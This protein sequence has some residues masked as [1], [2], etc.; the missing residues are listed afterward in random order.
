MKNTIK[1]SEDFSI[2]PWARYRTDWEFSG[3]AFYEDKL[4]PIYQGLW[5]DEK[6]VIDLD[7]VYWYPSSFLSESFWHLYKDFWTSVWDKIEFISNDDPLV[8]DVIKKLASK[9]E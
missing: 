8:I 3:Q 2:T 4:N 7:D 5:P 6:L 9:Y 1:I